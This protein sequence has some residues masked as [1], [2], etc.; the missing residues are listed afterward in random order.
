MLMAEQPHNIHKSD[1]TSTA[2]APS[3]PHFTPLDFRGR[4]ALAAVAE[5]RTH[6][7]G[8]L[9]G[10]MRLELLAAGAA[11]STMLNTFISNNKAA[12][13]LEFGFDNVVTRLV[14]A[15]PE[16]AQAKDEVRTDMT[17]AL[18]A[19]A[20]TNILDYH[21]LRK[22]TGKVNPP[23]ISFG[24]RK[25]FKLK[26]AV[27]SAQGIRVLLE[28]FEATRSGVKI[29]YRATVIFEI[30]DHFGADDDDLI[31]ASSGHGSLGQ[32]ALWLLQRERHAGHF[33][34]VPKIMIRSDL[35]DT[36]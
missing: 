6:S 29:S 35:T 13:E 24:V 31:T 23:S 4:A 21:V 7:T 27:G 18:A 14:E 3:G 11:G 1:L 26:I 12:A 36:L 15:S 20:A 16:F 32:I 33:P 10:M 17:A 22:E 34:F 25:S 30:F 8:E 19:S 9:E 28:D 5:A 2:V